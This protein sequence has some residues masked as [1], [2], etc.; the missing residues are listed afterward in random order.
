MTTETQKPATP[1][2]TPGAALRQAREAQGL[3]LEDIAQELMI[4][5]VYLQAMENGDRH[6]MP[7]RVFI[8]GYVRSYAQLL[9]LAPEEHIQAFRRFIGGSGKEQLV[10]P[11]PKL[12]SK[13]PEPQAIMIGLG[14]LAIILVVWYVI[15]AQ[16]DTQD[17]ADTIPTAGEVTDSVTMAAADTNPEH[18]L[19]PATQPTPATPTPPQEQNS[20]EAATTF[21]SAS[22]PQEASTPPSAAPQ[23]TQQNQPIETTAPVTSETSSS[24]TAASRI[25]IT[26]NQP[27]WVEISR[28]NGRVLFTKVM[29]PGQT[30]LVPTEPG[31]KMVTGN[32]GGITL[33]ID[34]VALPS[35][36]KPAEV[37]RDIA[38]DPAQL[39]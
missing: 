20:T 28:N 33:S 30:Y 39:R 1:D 9:G 10:M 14:A 29:E 35:I 37:V 5:P 2:R 19:A 27:S 23:N 26:A 4:R 31:L 34:G 32:A 6:N 3:K 12:I 21:L 7:E 18:A 8:L 24:D 25:L 13:R 15:N 11:Q 38:L 22:A 36:G 16:S 17:A